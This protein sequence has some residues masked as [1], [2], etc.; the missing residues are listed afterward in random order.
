MSDST[1]DLALGVHVDAVN[2]GV[3]TVHERHREVFKGTVGPKTIEGVAYTYGWDFPEPPSLTLGAPGAD[4]WTK[5]IKAPGV[6][7]LPESGVLQVVAPKLVAKCK[8]GGA[9]FNG[10]GK[11]AVALQL[12]VDGGGI[13]VVPLGVWLE[14]PPQDPDQS[15]LVKEVIV[16]AVLEQ[17]ADMVKGVKIPAQDLFGQRV[18]LTLVR[19]DVLPTHLVLAATAAPGRQAGAPGASVNWP[20]DKQVFTLVSKG[21]LTTLLSGALKQYDDK[22]LGNGDKTIKFVGSVWWN[23][24][25]KQATGLRIDDDPTKGSAQ[26]DVDW[27]AGLN[28]FP[29]TPDGSGGCALGKAGHSS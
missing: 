14:D 7:V 23:A 3:K 17:A 16:P 12:K 6:T 24:T 9:P 27:A 1:Y 28:L 25:F 4:L 8:V 10:T 19:V 22:Q 20:T 5:M 13:T 2:S 29:I 15:V 18:T 21:L 26:V 11:I